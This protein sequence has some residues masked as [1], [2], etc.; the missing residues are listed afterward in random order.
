[1]KYRVM[2]L[3]PTL[4]GDGQRLSPIDYM[5]WRDHVNV[6]DQRRI[7]KLLAKG[8]RLEGYLT[9]LKKAD[10]LD[11][12]SWGGFAQNFAGRRIPFENPGT[13]SVWERAHA[14][15]LFIPTFAASLSGPYL[16]ATAVKG[17]LRTGAVFD[18]WT[19]GTLKDLA[20]RIAGER[21]PRNPASKIEDVPRA[22]RVSMG[23]SRDA[24][25][26]A[27][28]VYLLR[29]STLVARGPAKGGSPDAKF[30]LGWKSVRGSTD[31]RR[32]E[33]ST[34]LF[35]EMATPGTTFEGAWSEKSTQDRTRLFQSANRY[36]AGQLA[37][38][39]HY[40]E[41]AGL[42]QV[43]ALLEALEERLK[44]IGGSQNVCMLS[45]GWG[46]GLHSKVACLDTEGAGYRS[47]LKQYSLYDRALQTGLPFPKTRRVI[48]ENNQPASLPGWVL[49]EVA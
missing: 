25:Y 4:V 6:L 7:F 48:F 23:D 37:R 15:N 33:E 24:T 47:V 5:V 19:E 49:L 39:K 20:E 14:E 17:A 46:G 38:H 12:A 3:T 34:P 42:G 26:S 41:S 40:A 21:P 13:V 35:A 16:P 11:F 18:R 22:K 27:M 29:V 1:M 30:E 10:R 31:S 36:A 43:A 45:V 28:K 9:Q 2:C 8:P 44:E 32:I